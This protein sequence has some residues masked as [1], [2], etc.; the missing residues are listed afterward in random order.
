MDQ[1]WVY[2]CGGVRLI[3]G[4]KQRATS[5][6][7]GINAQH[8]LVLFDNKGE[9]FDRAPVRAVEMKFSMMANSLKTPGHKYNVVFHPLGQEIGGAVGGL[10]GGAIAGG[11][12]AAANGEDK[13]SEKE[14]RQQFIDAF[15]QLHP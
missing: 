3:E 12:A 6:Y 5:G 4:V 8:E 9:E 13:R 14:K 15:K 2:F 1:Q 7:I 11:I 10:V